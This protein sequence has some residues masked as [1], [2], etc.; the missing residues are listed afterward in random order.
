MAHP[1]ESQSVSRHFQTVTPVSPEQGLTPSRVNP[2][3]SSFLSTVKDALLTPPTTASTLNS[4]RPVS[5]RPSTPRDIFSFN[6]PPLP[7]IKDGTMTIGEAMDL[8][9]KRR[10]AEGQSDV[11]RKRSHDSVV[12]MT[13]EVIVTVDES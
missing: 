11:S 13:V 9:A 12:N 1:C 8:E 6:I 2:V 4:P 3:L 5:R 7:A 10:A